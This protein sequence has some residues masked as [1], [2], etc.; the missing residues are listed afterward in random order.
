MLLQVSK[1]QE[2]LLKVK[3]FLP[4]LVRLS[5]LTRCIAT[6]TI[7]K[8]RDLLWETSGNDLETQHVSVETYR[9]MPYPEFPIKVPIKF[10]LGKLGM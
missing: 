5:V 4:P 2:E 3:I 7:C 9:N 10:S 6:S 8:M 1:K